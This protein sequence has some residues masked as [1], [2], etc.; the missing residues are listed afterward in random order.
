MNELIEL[1]ARQAVSLLKRGEVSPLELIEA[2]ADRIA[3][4]EAEVNAIPTLC[5]DRAR[6]HGRQLMANP[7]DDPPPHYLYG[8]PIAIKDLTDVS[9][10]RTTYGSTIFSDPPGVISINLS[11]IKPL[12][13]TEAI[14]SSWILMSRGRLNATRAR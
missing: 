10:V 4:V 13:L 12:V 14:A 3:E 2:S 11:P 6:D 8:L 1:T 7:R 5:L 9:G